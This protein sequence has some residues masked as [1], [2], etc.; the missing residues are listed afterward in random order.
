MAANGMCSACGKRRAEVT[1]VCHDR[2]TGARTE[3][4]LCAPFKPPRF[5]RGE[6]GKLHPMRMLTAA[7]VLRI[8][9]D[10]RGRWKCEVR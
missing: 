5:T 10:G 3:L 9:Y 2:L 7:E 6:L 1:T 8:C 4:H